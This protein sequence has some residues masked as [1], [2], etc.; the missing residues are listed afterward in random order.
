MNREVTASVEEMGLLANGTSARWHIEINECFN[1]DEWEIEIE[2]SHTYLAFQLDDLSTV[3]AM[4]DFLR[5]GPRLTPPDNGQE[6][7]RDVTSL[8]LGRFGSAAVSL[9][10]DNEDFLRC[11]LVIGR[12]G[13][14]TL[15]LSFDEE[16]IGMLIEA[17]EQVVEDLPNTNPPAAMSS[18]R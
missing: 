7:V 13:Y 6:N 2:A 11:F 4:L 10:W 17:L 12:E 3:R 16:D 9:I 15:R 8:S 18:R 14:S 1:R 5:T